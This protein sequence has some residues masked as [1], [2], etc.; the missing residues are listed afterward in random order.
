MQLNMVTPMDIGLERQD[1]VDD[2]DMFDLGEVEGGQERRGIDGGMREDEISDSGE[3]SMD[4]IE[5]EEEEEAEDEDEEKER[6]TAR[7]EQSLDQL[8]DQFQQ[9]KSD[10]DARHKAKEERRKRDAAEGG[11]WTGIKTT[12]D[13]DDESEGDLD[14]AP[15]PSDDDDSDD[16]DIP[17][18]TAE[19]MKLDGDESEADDEPSLP[20]TKAVPAPLLSKR[21]I[22]AAA[23]AAAKISFKEQKLMTKLVQPITAEKRLA[24][25]SKQAKQWFDQ[26]VFKGLKGL[27]EMMQG[28]APEEEDISEEEDEDEGDSKMWEEMDADEEEAEA[29]AL[30][31]RPHLITCD[32]NNTDPTPIGLR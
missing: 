22:K 3:S 17:A 20:L 24:D 19:G 12:E 8:Y 16:D 27:E 10:R 28:D 2:S 6:K 26:P 31:V 32:E 13:S 7:L 15:M 11:E 14:P 18:T 29:K 5:E 30:A 23:L 4:D 25:K 21:A 9:H 1:G